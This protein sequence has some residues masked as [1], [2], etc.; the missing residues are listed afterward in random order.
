MA[1]TEEKTKAR[2]NGS[3][4]EEEEEVADPTEPDPDDISVDALE[5]VDLS[6]P[7]SYETEL[8][9]GV[10][11]TAVGNYRTVELQRRA[12]RNASDHPQAEKLAKAAGAFRAEAAVI[13]HEYPDT[14]P[15][16]KVLAESKVLQ[17]QEARGRLKDVEG[18]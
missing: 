15:L 11:L 6:L 5:G 3:V 4:P 12:A 9:A 1:T 13:Q 2:K 7:H 18:R 10:L 8:L 14:V 16:Y 17:A